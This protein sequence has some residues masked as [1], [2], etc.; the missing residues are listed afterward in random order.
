MVYLRVID[1]SIASSRSWAVS[2]AVAL[3]VREAASG[4]TTL[5]RRRSA[6]SWRRASTWVSS[7]CRALRRKS[8]EA[9]ISSWSDKSSARG[10]RDCV[11]IRRHAEHAEFSFREKL[12]AP[13]LQFAL[14]SWPS[15]HAT[16]HEDHRCRTLN[17]SRQ[18]SP[19]PA[20]VTAG[21]QKSRRVPIDVES[22]RG[23]P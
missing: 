4:S 5:S 21:L 7:P 8:C 9:A 12:P 16:R 18:T 14:M 22:S 19:V 17:G 11:A 13:A 3:G 15:G 6:V 10:M 2:A 20:T 1:E 23:A